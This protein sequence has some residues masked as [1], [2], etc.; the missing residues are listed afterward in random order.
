MTLPK[1][2]WNQELANLEYNQWYKIW[3]LGYIYIVF[4]THMKHLLMPDKTDLRPTRIV[5]LHKVRKG[6]KR[7]YILVNQ[8][9]DKLSANREDLVLWVLFLEAGAY[10][11]WPQRHTA[12]CAMRGKNKPR[13]TAKGLKESPRCPWHDT[14]E[15]AKALQ[16][17][18]LHAWCLPKSTVT[19]SQPTWETNSQVFWGM[20]Q[21]SF[22]VHFLTS[23]SHKA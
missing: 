21:D 11:G 18:P 7:S 4:V 8:Q 12:E 15:K 3:G 2:N 23:S 14:P 10:L 5:D 17:I 1:L 22:R 6:C 16:K 13:G 19:P 20:L 9:L